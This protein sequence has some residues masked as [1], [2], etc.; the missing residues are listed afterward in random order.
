MLTP[1]INTVTKPIQCTATTTQTL[2][3]NAIFVLSAVHTA[4]SGTALTTAV[5]LTTVN[6]GTPT[7]GQILFE[8]SAIAPTKTVTLSAAATTNDIL[9][10][11]Y[12]VQGVIPA[13]A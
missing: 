11:T 2:P 6:T 9:E 3:D 8:G 13:A 1:T 12:A 4:G 7:T 5:A 10:V